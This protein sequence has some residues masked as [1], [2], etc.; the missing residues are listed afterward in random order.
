MVLKQKRYHES[1]VLKQNP[2][3]F[4]MRSWGISG[5]GG[6]NVV[7]GGLVLDRIAER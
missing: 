6:G 7:L 1:F 5:V 3:L 4:K 2:S